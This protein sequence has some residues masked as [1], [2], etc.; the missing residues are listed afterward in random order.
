VLRI[1]DSGLWFLLAQRRS[2]E[3]SSYAVCVSF[4]I[5]KFLCDFDFIHLLGSGIPNGKIF[6]N[7]LSDFGIAADS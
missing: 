3:Y 5:F 7:E 1:L 2:N 4:H 6:L